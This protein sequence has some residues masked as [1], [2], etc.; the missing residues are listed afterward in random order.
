MQNRCAMRKELE[1]QSFQR[2]IASSCPD[3]RGWV[4]HG[5]LRCH[6][7]LASQNRSTTKSSYGRISVS[8]SSKH[9]KNKKSKGRLICIILM[10]QDLHLILISPTL[11]KSLARLEKFL[12]ANLAA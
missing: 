10:N 1:L 5:E 6:S 9:D 3:G 8:V 4:Y 12:H 11:G 2:W 7:R